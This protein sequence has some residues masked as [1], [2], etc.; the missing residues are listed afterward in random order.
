VDAHDQDTVQRLEVGKDLLHLGLGVDGQA[1]LHPKVTCS[2]NDGR[3][4]L[5]GLHMAGD[6]V[7]PGPGEVLEQGVR[8][9]DH[10]VAMQRQLGNSPDGLH[11]HRA[12]G[13]HGD[14]VSIH[15]VDMD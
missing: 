2:P 13:E 15:T 9:L 6:D 7:G 8:T 10:E 1:G 11:H 3:R 5:H 4:V 14:E 12:H